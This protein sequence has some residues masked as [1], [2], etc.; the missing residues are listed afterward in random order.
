[1][2]NYYMTIHLGLSHKNQ[3][4]L[5]INETQ[6]KFNHEIQSCKPNALEY[7]SLLRRYINVAY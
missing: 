7:K 5:I 2:I 3:S 1:M 4:H 6:Y